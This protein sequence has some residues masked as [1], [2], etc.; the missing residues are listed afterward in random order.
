MAR[1]LWLKWLLRVIGVTA[2][3]AIVPVM[4]PMCW[5]VNVHDWLGLGQ[6][7]SAPIVGYLAGSL[8]AFYAFFGALCLVLSMNLDRYRPLLWIFAALL[9]IFGVVMTGIDFVAEMPPMWRLIERPSTIAMGV[10]LFVLAQP[11][12]FAA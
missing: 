9:A 6:M 7:P 4:M 11:D 2:L 10:A 5:M 1:E 8:P 12:V 3:A